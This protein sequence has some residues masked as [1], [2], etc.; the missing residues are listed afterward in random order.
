[1]QGFTLVTNSIDI[2]VISLYLSLYI[3]I[4][5]GG[6]WN[7]SRHGHLDSA[8]QA[9]LPLR[10]HCVSATRATFLLHRHFASPTLAPFLLYGGCFCHRGTYRGCSCMPL[11]HLMIKKAFAEAVQRSCDHFLAFGYVACKH[12]SE[13]HAVS[14]D[15]PDGPRTRSALYAHYICLAVALLSY[16]DYIWIC[17]RNWHSSG[18]RQSDF[19]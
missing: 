3:Y 5:I 6:P 17:R 4:Y 10:K 15:G 14:R 19:R 8:T 9:L 1:M 11:R 16:W 12:S 13:V 7:M 18:I 2:F